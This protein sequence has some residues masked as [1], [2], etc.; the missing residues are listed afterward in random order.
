MNSSNALEKDCAM[1]IQSLCDDVANSCW[2]RSV[3]KAWAHF[4]LG[5]FELH[6]ARRLGELQTLWEGRHELPPQA[7][8]SLRNARDHFLQ[9]ASCH[10]IGSDIISRF[11]LRGL[12]L[13]VG[14]ESGELSGLSAG[15]LVLSSIGQSFRQFMVRSMDDDTGVSN[16]TSQEIQ[17]AFGS[18]DGEFT[19]FAERD[20]RL[21]NFFDRFAELVPNNWKFVAPTICSSGE[22]LVTSVEKS[23]LDGTF[24]ISTTC[25]F[26][27][28]ENGSAYDDTMKPLDE[29]IRKS[30]EQLQG[31]DQSAVSEQFSKES[32]KRKWWDD[33]H[34]LDMDLKN[35]LERVEAVYFPS[36]HLKG[37]TNDSIFSAEESSLPCGNLAPR[38]RSR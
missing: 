24:S 26:P 32:A 4:Y 17:D 37:R 12:A 18:F 20:R 3:D 5:S 21:T 7:G 28:G 15:I 36:L 10:A 16:S 9:A 31:M 13:A 30:Q 6:E 35:L 29:I 2:S 33:R 19:D 38:G 34:Q 27:H 11:I 14:P 1:R 22:I 8:E 25:V 23:D